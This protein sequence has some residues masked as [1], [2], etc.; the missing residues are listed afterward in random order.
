MFFAMASNS[1]P[2]TPP[3]NIKGVA[4]LRVL[5]SMFLLGSFTRKQLAA[6]SGECIENVTSIVARHGEWFETKERIPT[7]PPGPPEERLVLRA[8]QEKKF[9]EVLSPLYK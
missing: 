9:L 1:R 5:R 8:S 2:I 6:H 3:L 7:G 4:Q